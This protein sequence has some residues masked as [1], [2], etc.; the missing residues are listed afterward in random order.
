MDNLE[1]LIKEVYARFGLAYY[2]GEVLHRGLCNVYA[3]L[4][5]ESPKEITRPRVEEKLAY[6]FSLTLGQTIKEVEDLLT[7][8]LN[9]EL[10]VALD[11][12][13]FLAHSFWFD[14]IHLM[15]NEQG[16]LQM[17]QELDEI[18][19]L[20]NSLDEKISKHLEP[21]CKE[22][23][24]TDDVIQHLMNELASGNTEE[25]LMSRR[26]LK[27]QER[28]VKVWDVKT[29]DNLVTQIFEMEDGTLWQLC[30]V[31]LGWSRFEKPSSDWLENQN[32][33]NYLPASINPRPSV[34][35]PWEY[36]FELKKRMIFWVKPGKRE[37]SYNWGLKK[38]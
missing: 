21:R 10:Q 24:V 19:Q 30:D 32:I 13:N 22:L 15:Y 14:R 37:R 5:F 12:R 38:S 16:L 18:G 23:G 33:Q 7:L 1:E 29:D 35:R 31:G 8:E 25:P 3:L 20:F 28:V 27:K 2:L 17:L 9:Q 4:T 36:E 11:K 26:R 34:S 6:V